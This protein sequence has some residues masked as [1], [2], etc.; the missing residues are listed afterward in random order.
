MRAPMSLAEFS[1][2][3]DTPPDQLRAWTD[4]GFLDP[5]GRGRYDELDLLRLMTIRHYGS[6]GYSPEALAA[7]I[8][9]GEVQP[10]LGEYLYPRGPELSVDEA[11]R[12]LS[13]MPQVLRSLR[14]ALGFTRDTILEDDLELFRSFSTMSAVGMP[15]E[16]VLEGARGFGATLRRR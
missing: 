13:I 6:L 8:S 15:F 11:A 1:A 14:T 4:A 16:A 9:G 10:F 5:A 12:R 7:A 2:L 3:V